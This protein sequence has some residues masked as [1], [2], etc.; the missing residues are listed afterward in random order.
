MRDDPLNM[1]SLHETSKVIVIGPPGSG[2]TKVGNLLGA[3]SGLPVYSTDQFSGTPHVKALHAVMRACGDKGFVL[4]GLIGYKWLRKRKQLGLPNPDVVV[5][6]SAT[7]K[8]IERSY[9]RRGKTCNLQLIHRFVEAHD[10]ILEDFYLLDGDL[11]RIHIHGSSSQ[12]VYLI[13]GKLEEMDR[14]EDSS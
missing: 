5:Q 2:K 11:P 7:D 12:I 14:D 3:D 6:L 13:A 4:E 9:E 8:E 10:K 1:L